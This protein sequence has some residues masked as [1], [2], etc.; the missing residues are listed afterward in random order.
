LDIN[1]EKRRTIPAQSALE[2]MDDSGNL[3]TARPKNVVTGCFELE[4]NIKC[5]HGVRDRCIG[6][7]A[8]WGVSDTFPLSVFDAFHFAAVT[9]PSDFEAPKNTWGWLL[10]ALQLVEPQNQ[11]NQM[12]SKHH[13]DPL[14]KYIIRPKDIWS[15]YRANDICSKSLL[16]ARNAGYKDV[17]VR[18]AP[19]L[20]T[21]ES[22]QESTS[23][24]LERTWSGTVHHLAESSVL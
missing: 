14:R 3:K 18:L 23:F 19:I 6:C 15:M 7:A 1:F 17:H 11:E 8:E 20:P 10:P 22:G 12:G 4:E 2:N 9:P 5:W 21:I 13:N 16:A 24:Q